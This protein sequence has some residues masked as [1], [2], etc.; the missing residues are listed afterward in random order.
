VIIFRYF[1]KEIFQTLVALTCILMLIFLSNQLV[2]Y[3][4]RAASG[5]IPVDLVFNL[6]L[7]EIPVLISLLL[8]LGFFIAVLISYGRLYAESEMVVLSACGFSQKQ[9]LS[10]TMLM[11]IIVASVAF[12]LALWVNPIV[13]KERDFLLT[14]SSVSAIIQAIRP[15]HFE[16]Q[17]GGQQVL[18]VEGK[19]RDQTSAR[20]LFLARLSPNQDDPG[21]PQWEVVVADNGYVDESVQENV[22]RIVLEQGHEYK[23]N[24]GEGN[25]QV[26]NFDRYM[27]RLHESQPHIR[28][29]QQAM[30]TGELWKQRHNNPAV[31]A[32]L[33]WR[34]SVP[35]M[36]FALAFL[37]VPISRVSPR[38]GKYGKLL[39]AILIYVVYANMMFFVRDWI[40][41]GTISP[42][43]GVWW[44]H[45]SIL[46]LGLVL[47]GL[48]K[49]KRLARTFLRRPV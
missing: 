40:A 9:L 36:T 37:A 6:L 7:L 21:H 14:G 49:L 31:A 39:P 15:G 24:P 4:T 32:E 48:P 1:A 26:V 42:I 34:I 46:I 28:R 18:Y 3:I 22:D 43:L 30:P 2:Q 19:S 5:Q 12:M 38:R 45:A 33:Q 41:K 10:M 35:L 47:F 27:T 20:N 16:G 29:E 25:Y 8:P 11:S 17:A 23:G 44:L 13:S